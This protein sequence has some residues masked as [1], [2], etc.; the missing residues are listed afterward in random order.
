MGSAKVKIYAQRKKMVS[1]V[2]PS[3]LKR[4]EHAY[5]AKASCK[6]NF[7]IYL[8]SYKTELRPTATT[9]GSSKK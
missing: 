4:K 8:G 2:A 6:L 5:N 1:V 3:S 7:S 9:V